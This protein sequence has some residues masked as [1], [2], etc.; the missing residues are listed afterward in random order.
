MPR[1]SDNASGAS[2]F[3]TQNIMNETSELVIRD[4]NVYL[5]STSEIELPLHSSSALVRNRSL[6]VA[7]YGFP[8]LLLPK[9]DNDQTALANKDYI[10]DSNNFTTV[11]EN[12]LCCY[13][14]S[15]FFVT[16]TPGF[17]V[18]AWWRA[19][20]DQ[21]LP[22]LSAF[23]A[24]S[25]GTFPGAIYKRVWVPIPCVWALTFSKSD[26][27]GSYPRVTISQRSA[28]QFTSEY[29]VAMYASKYGKFSYG[30]FH[31]NNDQVLSRETLNTQFR[32][33]PC[34]NAGRDG[35]LCTGDTGFLSLMS[36]T[37]IIYQGSLLMRWLMTA[38]NN[39][40]MVDGRTFRYLDWLPDSVSDE[41]F[42]HLAP[43]TMRPT[44]LGFP[45]CGNAV[46]N[47]PNLQSTIAM[48][49]S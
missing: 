38:Q 35:H 12:A 49:L 41:P 2:S 9:L 32:S 3:I 10:Y 6:F 36:H 29:I 43:T 34:A 11:H 47:V 48:L 23:F 44:I 31:G 33:I 22:G 40:D 13:G 17:Y 16:I 15:H 24:R 46:T 37:S 18:T 26:Q 14:Q 21:G 25:N 28:F 27:P 45:P 19:M 4:G 39:G 7:D 1:H 8:M 20:R 30:R 5:K 42:P